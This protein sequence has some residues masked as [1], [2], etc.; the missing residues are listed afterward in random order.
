MLWGVQNQYSHV[1]TE[2]VRYELPPGTAVNVSLVGTFRHTEAPYFGTLTAS[3]ADGTRGSR[4]IEGL[5]MDT[6]LILLTARYSPPFSLSRGPSRYDVPMREHVLYSSTTTTTT[7]T[8]TPPSTAVPPKLP[9]VGLG[10]GPGASQ[11]EVVVLLQNSTGSPRRG[12]LTGLL[13]LVAAAV[14]LR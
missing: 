1:R 14:M 5:H 4:V 7:T 13:A 11:R 2:E 12:S 10:A 8:P 6:R 9:L 3:Y